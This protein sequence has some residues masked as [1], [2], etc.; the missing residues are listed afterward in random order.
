MR[1]AVPGSENV[2][3]QA[4]VWRGCLSAHGCFL[5]KQVMCCAVAG[6]NAPWGHVLVPS[7]AQGLGQVHSSCL[8]L[9]A[10]DPHTPTRKYT[11]MEEEI[12][13][14][15]Q[16]WN[17]I[18]FFFLLNVCMQLHIRSNAPHICRHSLSH[19]SQHQYIDHNCPIYSVNGQVI[20]L[21]L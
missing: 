21:A 17:V 2:P 5:L 3:R 20:K 1:W 7:L 14:W 4:H 9:W 12:S 10:N 19:Y 16:D 8:S 11:P 18:F 6:E 13:L 15:V